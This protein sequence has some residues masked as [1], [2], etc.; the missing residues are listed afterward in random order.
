MTV[1]QYALKISNIVRRKG[2]GQPS[3]DIPSDGVFVDVAPCVPIILL[4]SYDPIIVGFLPD[5]LIG[6]GTVNQF[7]NGSLVLPENDR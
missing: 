4:I 5:F 2:K 6:H 3:V 1:P 7:G